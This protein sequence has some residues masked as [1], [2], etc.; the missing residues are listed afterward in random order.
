MD[1][2]TGG[3]LTSYADRYSGRRLDAEERFPAVE[4]FAGVWHQ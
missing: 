2:S 3:S 1:S 4:H